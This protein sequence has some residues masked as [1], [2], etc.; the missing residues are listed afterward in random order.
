[1]L[2]VCLALSGPACAFTPRLSAQDIEEA[3]RSGAQ[4]A[5]SRTHGYVVEDYVL[6]DV[7]QPLGAPPGAKEVE[8]VVLGT[9]FERLRYASYLASIQGEPLTDAGARRQARELDD[10]LHVVVF[11]HSP[12]ASEVDRGFLQR[13]RDVRLEIDGGQAIEPRASTVFGPAQD[14][15]SVQGSGRERRWLGTLTWEF[16]LDQSTG[17]GAERS[18]GRLSFVDSSGHRYEVPF[19]LG[20]YR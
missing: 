20:K 11:A 15:F 9:P 12:G 16:A 2:G 13:Y 17:Q 3:R 14:F 10:T 1:M 18:R 8:A 5:D 7:Q 4:Q 19:D 6:Y